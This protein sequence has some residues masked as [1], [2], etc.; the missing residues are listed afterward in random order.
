MESIKSKKKKKVQYKVTL[1]LHRDQ[2]AI[3]L[4]TEIPSVYWTECLT[5][6]ICFRFKFKKNVLISMSFGKL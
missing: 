2:G 6:Y 3:M 4:W 1:N 5:K